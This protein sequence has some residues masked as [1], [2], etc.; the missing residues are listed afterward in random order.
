[1]TTALDVAGYIQATADVPRHDT[2]KLQKLVYFSQAWALGWTGRPIFADEFQAWPDGPVVSSL[3]GFQRH[4]YVPPAPEGSIDQ[5]TKEIIDSVI[6][7]YGHLNHQQLIDL[8]HEHTPWVEARG[9]LPAS[10]SSNVRISND[11]IRSFYTTRAILGVDSP[12]RR[13]S[14]QIAAASTVSEIGE[15]QVIRWR[16]GL[17]IL[18]TR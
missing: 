7:H 18:A 17:D 1:M 15:A 13:L 11:A 3:F 9:S 14:A 12:R 16:E 8:T 5:A 2:K 10:A 6:E 4:E